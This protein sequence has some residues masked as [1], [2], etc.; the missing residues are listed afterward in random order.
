MDRAF[1][2]H[3][4]AAQVREERVDVHS[5]VGEG[6]GQRRDEGAGVEL[7]EVDVDELAG[8]VLAHLEQCSVIDGTCWGNDFQ[9]CALEPVVV[10]LN[11]GEYQLLERLALARGHRAHH[12]EVDPLDAV[13]FGHHDVS[14]MWVG[15]VE[16]VFHDLLHEVV[17]NEVGQRIAL[18]IGLAHLVDALDGRRADEILGQDRAR[19]VLLVAFRRGNSLTRLV[20]RVETHEIRFLI[21]EVELLHRGL[22]EFA[23]QIFQRQATLILVRELQEF[24][25]ALHDGQVV[26]HRLHDARALDLHSYDL[27]GGQHSPMDLRNGCRAQGRLVE[28]REQLV[29]RFAEFVFNLG[30]NVSEIERAGMCA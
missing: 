1:Q 15:V 23:D 26:R 5:H 2:R 8:N 10:A 29:H 19:G 16:T 12:A 9:Y 11:E 27:A 22:H 24:H 25:Q 18:L 21:G 13:V 20:V 28:F 14:G 6:V 4:A 30:F 3:Q 17:G 7:V